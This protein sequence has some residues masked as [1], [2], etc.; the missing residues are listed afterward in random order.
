MSCFS[1][2]III[3]TTIW[4]IT[5]PWVQVITTLLLSSL[6]S[7]PNQVF[8][9]IQ[10]IQAVSL[11]IP[12]I[13]IAFFPKNLALKTL[14]Q[15]WILTATFGLFLAPIQLLD[16][17]SSQLRAL[18]ATLAG[19]LFLVI[20]LSFSHVKYG[21]YYPKFLNDRYLPSQNIFLI[22]T[23]TAFFSYPW[24][25]W[26]SF[27]SVTDTFVALINAAVFGTLLAFL[28]EFFLYYPLLQ[29]DLNPKL[30]LLLA[31]LGASNALS[32]FAS[33]LHFPFGGTQL[34]L[35]LAL[36]GTGL[37][38][39]LIHQHNS[40]I[41]NKSFFAL[42]ILFSISFAA[43]ILFIDPDEL[44]VVI[45]TSVG[46]IS[47]WALYAS[48]VSMGFAWLFSF[49]AYLWKIIRKYLTKRAHS[50][51]THK[52][53]GVSIASISWGFGVLLYFIAGNP[54]CYGEDLFIILTDQ[55]EISNAEKFDN[56]W[57]RREYVYHTLVQHANATQAE[58]RSI[59]D[60]FDLQYQPYYLVNAIRVEGGLLV[61]LW[62]TTRPEVDRVLDN[63]QLR[64]LHKNPEQQ[65]GSESL[66]SDSMWNISYIQA[67]L[68]WEEFNITG[69][70][71]TIGQSDSGVQW[72]HSELLDSYRGYDGNHDYNWLNPWYGTNEPSDINGHGTH[73]LGTILGNNIGIAPDATWFACANLV[74]N[75]GNPAY[76][77][78]CMQ[79]MLAPYPSS[80][81]PF[82]DGDPQKGAHI[83]NNS[84]SC[85]DFEGCDTDTLL[86][87]IRNLNAA[88]VFVVA[89]GGNEG[90]SCG[91]LTNPP[92]NYSETFTVGALDRH[93]ELATFSSIGPSIA[94]NI[95][96]I[97]PDLLAPGVDILSST[98][99]NTYAR[100]SGT[101]MASPHVAGVIALMWSANS[102]LIGDIEATRN[103]LI[104]SARPYTGNLPDCPG[105]SSH[106]S[107]AVGYGVLNAY[108][109]VKL[110]LQLK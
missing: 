107:N 63:P 11:I 66:S 9:S 68:V 58:L 55:A 93:G 77:L 80:K 82:T 10:F 50:F 69:E 24:I 8:A 76:Y 37:L 87:A 6:L 90:P 51:R 99:E 61:R 103:I 1:I 70:G 83:I 98:P 62:L 52:Y 33:E 57:K 23:C 56:Y 16:Q 95:E 38:A 5:I 75:L 45:N 22:L 2:I 73:T 46:E 84:W 15:T 36:P 7:V 43:P 20:L 39:Y 108:E 31:V 109:A 13:L 59:F 4:T 72:N 94:E 79:F 60:R 3:F 71:I 86:H 97:K 35:M 54:G 74:R 92:A 47:T 25:I 27:G 110:A 32:I 81:D 104:D 106:P 19:L 30:K 42:S 17:T 41:S 65:L 100:H 96:I 49:S 26:G 89:A 12:L 88:G 85:P 101:S 34:I 40:S 105:V 48:L 78:D 44:A 91:T 53:Q 14:F 18:I 67:D 64:P 28:L 29:V 21:E 102:G